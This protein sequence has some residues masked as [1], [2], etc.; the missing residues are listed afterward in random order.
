MRKTTSLILVFSGFIE[1]I[2]SIFL[3]MAPMGRIAYW[4]DYRFLWMN[5]AQ[6]R[7]IHI[8]VGILFLLA[9]FIHIYLNWR[10]LLAYLKNKSKQLTIFNKNFTI[11]FFITLYFM[12]GTLYSLPPMVQIIQFGKDLTAQANNKYSEPPFHHAERAS[13]QK[14]CAKMKI[15]PKSAAALLKGAG[16]TVE[17]FDKKM[18]QIAKKNSRS[19]QQIYEILQPIIP[20]RKEK[21]HH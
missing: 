4:H 2:T 13:L 17:G 19:P 8:T 3:Y 14:F 7:D 6:W 15:S 9:A 12:I 16:I 21:E 18:M 10:P 20:P 5:R 1:F 11:A